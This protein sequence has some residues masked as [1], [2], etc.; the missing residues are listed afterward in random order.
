[1]PT[2]HVVSLLN[3]CNDSNAHGAGSGHEVMDFRPEFGHNDGSFART[4]HAT[5]A[6]KMAGFSFTPASGK[7]SS[8]GKAIKAKIKRKEQG[9]AL[10]KRSG[11]LAGYKAGAKRLKG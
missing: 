9:P 6:S 5:G 7:V 11:K 10:Q 4:S 3:R 2:C 8:G 1:M